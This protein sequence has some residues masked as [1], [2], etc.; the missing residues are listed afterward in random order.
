MPIQNSQVNFFDIN[1]SLQVGDIVYYT[2]NGSPIGGFDNSILANTF[3]FGVVISI[4]NSNNN[5]VVEWNNDAPHPGPP[6]PGSYISFAKDKRVNTSSLLGY[7][8]SVKLVNN[9]REKVELFAIGS[10]I[11][12]SSK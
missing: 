2:T 5:I 12:E 3:M 6:P 7:Y 1:I 9:S 11:S 10:E 4:D 8:A